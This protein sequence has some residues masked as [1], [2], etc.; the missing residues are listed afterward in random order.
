M[1]NSIMASAVAAGL[2]AA[3]R[4]FAQSTPDST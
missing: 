4:G 3:A 1:R 2:L